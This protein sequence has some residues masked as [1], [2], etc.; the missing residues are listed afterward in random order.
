[1]S[2]PTIHPEFLEIVEF[3]KSRR[4]KVKI[5]TNG[6]LHD[7]EYWSELGRLL[8]SDDE[9][10]FGICGST[11]ELHQKYRK[12]TDLNR[13][14]KNAKALRNEK[15]VDG[16]KAIRFKYNADDL[17]SPEFKRI[18][19]QFTRFEITDTTIDDELTDEDFQPMSDVAER[20]KRID[21]LARFF[22]S[23]K[24]GNEC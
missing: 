17:N 9:V 6:N 22:N 15:P 19:S 4:L 13:I 5:C 8:D 12:N 11:N 21:K 24:P 20:F 14:L 2:E 3:V 16:I 1:M 23:T 18:A 10:W 7:E